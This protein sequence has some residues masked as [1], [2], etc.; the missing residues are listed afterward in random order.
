MNKL[1]GSGL[2]VGTCQC[3][4]SKNGESYC[5]ALETQCVCSSTPP[6]GC[7]YNTNHCCQ[8]VGGS[9]TGC[10]SDCGSK[11]GTE[12][13]SESGTES[14]SKSGTES[15]SKSGTE[16]GC[17]SDCGSKSGTESGSNS[18]SDSRKEPHSGEGEGAIKPK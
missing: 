11:S 9:E 17:G 14:G 8:P 16:F 7:N 13:G 4:S 15:G 5:R 3:G 12:S 10:G 18:D 2:T 1:Y 6:Q